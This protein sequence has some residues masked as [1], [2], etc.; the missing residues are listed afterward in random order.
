MAR[1]PREI[2]SDYERWKFA[3]SG[4]P[5]R[6]SLSGVATI[7]LIGLA[8][9]DNWW[10]SKFRPFGIAVALLLFVGAAAF[11][12]DVPRRRLGFVSKA[13]LLLGFAVVGILTVRRIIS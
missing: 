6:Y 7:V 8:T 11:L 2:E 5:F 4:I 10:N 3:G 12:Y 1:D 9:W 13:L